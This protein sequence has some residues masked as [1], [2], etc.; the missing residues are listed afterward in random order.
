M[1]SQNNPMLSHYM[2][3]PV[4]AILAVGS[5]IWTLFMPLN[6][7]R[8]LVLAVQTQSCTVQT[9]G[10]CHT[11]TARAASWARM[12]GI[13]QAPPPSGGTLV[14][15]T[16]HYSYLLH[17]KVALYWFYL[18]WYRLV[19]LWAWKWVALCLVG[20]AIYA[21]MESRGIRKET[22]AASSAQVAAATD[23][24]RAVAI[25]VGLTTIFIPVYGSLW[26]TRGCLAIW[27][28]AGAIRVEH[29]ARSQ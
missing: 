11:M 19:W 12:A 18:V 28:L 7:L 13:A 8:N 15:R 2:L 23:A 5:M 17:E 21:G 14:A 26:I 3:L 27:A 10:A 16:A 25:A 6:K 24:L 1:A 22:A 29:A 20:V 9:I 4:V